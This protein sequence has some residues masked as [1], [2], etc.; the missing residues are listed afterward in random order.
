MKCPNFYAHITYTHS[1][2]VGERKNIKRMQHLFA[3]APYTRAQIQPILIRIWPQP[4]TR[5]CNTA[6]TT[7]QP[8]CVCR[9]AFYGLVSRS[10]LIILKIKRERES[11]DAKAHKSCNVAKGTPFCNGFNIDEFRPTTYTFHPLFYILKAANTM[12]KTYKGGKN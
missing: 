6:F 7:C 11:N 1:A 9:A 8:A 2:G 4:A 10:R 12:L 5:A 3:M